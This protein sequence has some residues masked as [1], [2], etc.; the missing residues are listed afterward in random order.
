MEINLD[1]PKEYSFLHNNNNCEQTHRTWQTAAPSHTAVCLSIVE[2]Q[3][4]DNSKQE[5][6]A[7]I[8]IKKHN[9]QSGKKERSKLDRYNTQSN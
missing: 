1:K 4:Y 2:L 5:F 6:A 9:K 8:E 3:F 7:Y